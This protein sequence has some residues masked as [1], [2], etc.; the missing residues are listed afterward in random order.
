MLEIVPNWH[1]IFVHFTVALLT[2]AVILSMVTPFIR[3]AP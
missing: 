3:T 2:L 1:P